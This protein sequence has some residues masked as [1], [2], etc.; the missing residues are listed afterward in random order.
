MNITIREAVV[1]DAKKGVVF[2]II[3][4]EG[5]FMALNETSNGI[6]DLVDLISGDVT[7]ANSSAMITAY[8]DAEL[9]VRAKS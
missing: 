7:K 8:P 9:I 4:H 2:S 3:G 6:R 1:A 5:F